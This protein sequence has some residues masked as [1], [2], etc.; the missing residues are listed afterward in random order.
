MQQLLLMRHLFFFEFLF[1]KISVGMFR[2][3]TKKLL[4]MYW[5]PKAYLYV[6]KDYPNWLRAFIVYSYSSCF[7]M[8]FF[9]W[10]YSDNKQI[11]LNNNS[12]IKIY[13][14][15][16][17]VLFQSKILWITMIMN[18]NISYSYQKLSLMICACI[19]SLRQIVYCH[20]LQPID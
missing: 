17:D 11:Y 3:I 2:T 6:W 20:F 7:C 4:K 10:V 16:Y 15:V 19:T 12:N 9:C 13:F 18:E 14:S 8:V 1:L 5:M